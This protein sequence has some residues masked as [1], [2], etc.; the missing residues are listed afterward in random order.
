MTKALNATQARSIRPKPPLARALRTMLLGGASLFLATTASAIPNHP[1][2]AP[3][4]ASDMVKAYRDCDPAA[5]NDVTQN[6]F[7]PRPA[8]TPP[9]V[10]SPSCLFSGTGKGKVKM[11]VLSNG[12]VRYKLKMRR[13]GSAS[14]FSCGPALPWRST[15]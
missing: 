12:E 4:F 2:S 6:A 8:C 9:V 1:V 5:A 10:E 13:L 15:A 3:G 11:T 14:G 7:F